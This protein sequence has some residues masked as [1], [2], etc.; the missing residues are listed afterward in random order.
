[1]GFI[2][3]GGGKWQEVTAV[4]AGGGAKWTPAPTDARGAWL[5]WEFALTG[6]DSGM[7]GGP[8]LDLIYH[9]KGEPI[10]SSVG[11]SD[12]GVYVSGATFEQDVAAAG[13]FHAWLAPVL[14]E[15]NARIA[16]KCAQLAPTPPLVLGYAGSAIPATFQA[17]REWLY[18]DG[19]WTGGAVTPQPGPQPAGT[20]IWGNRWFEN[21][22]AYETGARYGPDGMPIAR[23]CRYMKPNVGWVMLPQE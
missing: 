7:G 2:R 4:G 15:I 21:G 10:W 19:T 8:E 20:I 3:I 9:A 23:V 5:G 6:F 14:A 11:A 22:I 16:A 1:M 12:G 17:F 18:N 13:G